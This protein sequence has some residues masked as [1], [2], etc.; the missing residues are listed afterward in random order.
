MWREGLKGSAV[1][2][3]GSPENG[4]QSAASAFEEP[5]QVNSKNVFATVVVSAGLTLTTSLLMHSQD[6]IK[7]NQ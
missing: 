1:A 6:D 4:A 5:Q 3:A 2:L 7:K